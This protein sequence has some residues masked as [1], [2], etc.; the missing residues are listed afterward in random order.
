MLTSRPIKDSQEVWNKY[1]VQIWD[2][3]SESFPFS[4][5]KVEW[6]ISQEYF[7]A[8]EIYRTSWT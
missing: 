7:F 3:L 5:L 8:Q 2:M 6:E 1:K 4:L